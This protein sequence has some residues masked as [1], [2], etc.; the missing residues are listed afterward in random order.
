MKVVIEPSSAVGVAA[1]LGP[2]RSRSE[3]GRVG[4]VLCG[5]NIDLVRLPELIRVTDE[6]S[7]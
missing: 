5:G 3:L 1:V 4:V 7:T 2:L 6:A